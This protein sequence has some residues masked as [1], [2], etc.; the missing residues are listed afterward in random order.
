MIETQLIWLKQADFDFQA[1][2]LSLQNGYYEWACFQAQ[3]TAEKSLKAY[4]IFCGY[5][6]P[7]VHRVSVLY[8][9]CQRVNPEFRKIY[10]EHD[11][12]EAITFISRYPLAIPQETMTPHEFINS[13]EAQECLREA[14]LILQRVQTLIY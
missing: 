2:N 10:L 13:K 5:R 6:I 14:R 11:N 4:L 1:A 12:L 9:M 3:Q 8:K 7:R